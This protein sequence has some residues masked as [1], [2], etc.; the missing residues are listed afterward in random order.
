[1]KRL[2]HMVNEHLFSIRQQIAMIII[3]IFAFAEYS[4]DSYDCGICIF[5]GLPYL[6]FRHHFDSSLSVNEP[7]VISIDSLASEC[8]I[9][10]VLL[11][12]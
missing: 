3:T 9:L 8:L 7:L 6:L 5:C 1:M 11:V 12:E 2:R 10:H 4:A